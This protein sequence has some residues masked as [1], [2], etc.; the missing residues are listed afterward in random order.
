MQLKWLL[1]MDTK[2]YAAISNIFY[3]PFRPAPILQNMIVE[4]NIFKID[5]FSRYLKELF[6]E[7]SITRLDHQ[8][9]LIRKKFLRQ[10]LVYFNEVVVRRAA[11]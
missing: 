5:S 8:F 6:D 2:M 7:N 4:P 3:S 11:S 10:A 1:D 9:S